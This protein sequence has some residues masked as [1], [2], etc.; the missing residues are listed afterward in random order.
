MTLSALIPHAADPRNPWNFV[1]RDGVRV[2]R[3]F[4][5]RAMGEPNYCYATDGKIAIRLDDWHEK[6]F[7]PFDK[8]PSMKG[9]FDSIRNVREWTPIPEVPVCEKCN[10]TGIFESECE[11][12]DGRKSSYC[13]HCEKDHSCPC[14]EGS[15][16]GPKECHSDNELYYCNV[17]LFNRRIQSRLFAKIAPLPSVEIGVANNDSTERVYFRFTGGIGVVM[18]LRR[19]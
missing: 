6:E 5:Q 14:C 13:D 19:D 10:N 16:K 17:P 18:P 3:P 9:I 15:G 1:E 2:P 12:C 4:W 11:S 7:E 8:I